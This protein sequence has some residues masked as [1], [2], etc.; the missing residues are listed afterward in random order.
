MIRLFYFT[1][2]L[3]TELLKTTANIKYVSI[4]ILSCKPEKGFV[5]FLVQLKKKVF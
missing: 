3:A 1:T 4:I 2:G 5:L